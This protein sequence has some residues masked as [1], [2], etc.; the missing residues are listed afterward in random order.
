MSI[1]AK[2]VAVIE[3][4]RFHPEFLGIDLVD[5]NQPGAVD[6]TLLHLAART[7]AVEDIEVLVSCGA[8]VNVVGD[9]GNTPLHQAAMSGQEDSVT[10]LLRLGADPNLQN[11]F[12]QT[13]LQ[14]AELGGHERIVR[15]LRTFISSR[16]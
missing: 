15:I 13:A 8:R 3:K 1:D 10:L 14:V 4:Y 6:D 12:N 5:P 9:L 7:G 16:T 11:E 2:L